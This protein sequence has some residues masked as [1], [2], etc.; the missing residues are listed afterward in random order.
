[1]ELGLLTVPGYHGSEDDHWQ[2]WLEREFPSARRVSRIDWESPVLHTWAKEIIRALDESPQPCILI[3]HSFG[4][5]ASA[6]AIARRPQRV[7]GAIFVAPADP[8]RFTLLG[9]RGAG[10]ERDPT[11]AP[12]LPERSL[13]TPGYLIGSE[14]DP[15]LALEEGYGWARRWKLGFINA[16]HAGHINVAS[17]H[18]RWPW[19]HALTFSM[20]QRLSRFHAANERALSR[21]AS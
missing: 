12:F 16:G 2:S 13:G 20:H 10:R 8:E 17:G 9:F 21:K 19:I 11:I 18:G 15:W 1:M 3:S 7:A 4:C 6:L 14:N 5:L